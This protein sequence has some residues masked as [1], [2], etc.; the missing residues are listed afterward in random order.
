MWIILALAYFVAAVAC[1]VMA[2][3]L[4]IRLNVVARFVVVGC[5]IGALLALILFVTFGVS[6]EAVAS[7]LVYALLGELY[8]FAFTLVSSS[9]SA[10]LLVT[11]LGGRL[12][13]EAIE[14]R[15]SPTYMVDSRLAKLE[16]NGFLARGAD[17]FATTPKAAR[18][19]A[20]F[21]RLRRLFRHPERR[22]DD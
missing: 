11:L 17:G 2:T 19:M 18:T 22:W 5:P 21:G 15:Y 9:V 7:M 12:S 8:I 6:L 13:A 4:P 16:D 1:H 3:R 20:L 10:S 14:R